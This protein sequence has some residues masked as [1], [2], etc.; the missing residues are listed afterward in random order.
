MKKL[1][2]NIDDIVTEM[3]K[4]V[5][6]SSNGKLKKLD[7]Y[8]VVIRTNVNNENVA[9]ISGGGSGHEPAHAGF[10][11]TGML[12][13][14]VCGEVFTSP[15]PDAVLSAIKVAN[16]KQ[17]TLLVIKNYTGDLINFQ[18]AEEM[19]QDEGLKVDHVVVNDDVAL[20]KSTTATGRRGIAGTILV[21]KIAGAAAEMGKDLNEVKRIAEKV[22]ANTA[23]MGLGLS[24][25]TV[26]AAGKPGFTLPDNEIEMGL[27]IHG[28]PGIA[29]VPIKHVKE[30]VKDIVNV[31][32]EEIQLSKGQ[33]VAV[34][35]NGMGATPL[36]EL[37]IAAYNL[38][39]ELDALGL[40]IRYFKTGNYMTA[41][42]MHGMSITISKLDDETEK[43]LKEPQDTLAW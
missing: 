6:V 13:A 15:T 16:S 34:I 29:R 33:K 24:A 1:I 14:A 36:M 11:G 37:Y 17:G 40:N 31:I 12:T 41:I 9:L 20:A 23:T 32:K 18:V 7:D 10:V 8:N 30:L 26:P 22:I 25:C 43:L 42:D 35:V 21:H 2:N 39:D 4:G 3:T 28:E 38:K 27:G 19:A 5:V